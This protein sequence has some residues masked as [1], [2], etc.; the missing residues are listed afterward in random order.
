MRHRWHPRGRS[1][2]RIPHPRAYG[3]VA[4][5]LGRYVEG[6]KLIPLEEAIRRLTTLPATTFHLARRGTL[7]PGYLADVVV[8]DPKS[9]V[10]H[11]TFEDPHQFATGVT[12]VFVNG[13]EVLR[14]GEPT[15]ATPGR[16]VRGPGWQ[17][18]SD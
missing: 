2:S 13:V 18:G 10:D 3:N 17:P 8:L 6:E 15:G 12:E 14:G 4:R 7:A 9:I 16:I 5:L 1:S 11:A